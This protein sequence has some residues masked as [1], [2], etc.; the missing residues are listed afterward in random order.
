MRDIIVHS[1][2]IGAGQPCFLAAEIGINHNGDAILAKE[3]IDAA[4]EAGA[5]AVKFQNYRTEDFLHDRSLTY[6][7]TSQGKT[8]TE[9]QFA[10]FKRC[11]LSREM[12]LDLKQHCDKRGV[13]F[14]S[15]PTGPDG[16]RE[17]RDMG[18]AL[19]KNGSDYLQNLPLIADMARSGI[20]T[21]LSTGM[22]TL[23]EIEDA[24]TC[25]EQAG[26]QDL[27]LLVCT[28]AYP[29]PRSEANLR[30]IPELARTLGRP[31]GFSDHTE[32]ILAALGAVA[33]GA[34]LVEKHFTLHKKLPGPDQWFSADPGE[35]GE[36]VRGVRDMETC[37]GS[38]HIGPTASESLSREQFRLSCAAARALSSGTVLHEADVML[39]RPGSGLP[40]KAMAALAGKTLLRDL[41]QG[42]LLRW[43][44]LS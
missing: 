32:G 44:D 27:V 8:I 21:V 9:S 20:P 3:M 43:E 18:S 19:M 6:T 40:P 26:G 39:R 17:L 13:V 36:L 28:S 29:T 31:C 1:R 24:V 33:L 35:F 38:G 5:D 16:V 41:A 23:E 22:A 42:E 30:R 10:M 37:L 2:R 12:L 14:F 25:F 34:V 11:E 4:A 15:T 7:Y